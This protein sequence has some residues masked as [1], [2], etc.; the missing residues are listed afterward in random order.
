MARIRHRS[1]FDRVVVS[2][3]SCPPPEETAG[4]IGDRTCWY[5][6]LSPHLR[7][8]VNPGG[9]CEGCVQYES[10]AHWVLTEKEE[11]RSGF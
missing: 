2:D 4:V 3:L 1:E 6:A 10:R 8:A 11:N 9:P 5:N 7:C